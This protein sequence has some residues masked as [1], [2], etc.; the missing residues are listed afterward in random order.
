M[1]SV[2]VG[3]KIGQLQIRAFGRNCLLVAAAFRD[4]EGFVVVAVAAK[5]VARVVVEDVVPVVSGVVLFRLILRIRWFHVI[6][7]IGCFPL[8]SGSDRSCLPEYLVGYCF[9][10]LACFAAGMLQ[11]LQAENFAGS[12]CSCLVAGILQAGNFV[13]NCCSGFVA[14]MLQS[15]DFAGYC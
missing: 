7:N 8:L 3:H 4:P 6:W 2:G 10:E 15:E 14:G 11:M 9:D 12:C 5:V 13:G 1:S